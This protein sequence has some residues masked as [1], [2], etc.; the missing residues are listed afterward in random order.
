MLQENHVWGE[1]SMK[2]YFALWPSQG[3]QNVRIDFPSFFLMAHILVLEFTVEI[4]T[5]TFHLV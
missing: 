5:V 4:F 2:T 1:S 3:I